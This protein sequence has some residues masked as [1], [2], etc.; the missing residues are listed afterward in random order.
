MEG[1]QPKHMAGCGSIY[2][3]PELIGE[4][5]YY[6]VEITGP[7]ADVRILPHGPFGGE[8]DASAHQ[9]LLTKTTGDLP[10]SA[11]N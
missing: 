8:E 7:P 1:F 10:C 6:F 9:Q 2:H 3:P 4:Y 5:W 11:F